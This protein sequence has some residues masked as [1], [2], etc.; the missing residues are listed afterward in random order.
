MVTLL[1][2]SLCNTGSA[3]WKSQFPIAAIRQDRM[4]EFSGWQDFAFDHTLI[5]AP[6]Q[7]FEVFSDQLRV[8]KREF[9]IFANPGVQAANVHI[10]NLF[11]WSCFV[12]QLHC[13]CSTPIETIS[14]VQWILQLQGLEVIPHFW[15]I[16]QLRMQ[17][18]FPHFSHVVS[19]IF[20]VVFSLQSLLVCLCCCFLAQWKM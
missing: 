7:W 16:F 11:A 17:L 13:I 12:V 2:I 14:G 20:K 3:K 1:L 19:T 10:A 8:S 4:Q 6:A 9:S 18:T 15:V 5:A